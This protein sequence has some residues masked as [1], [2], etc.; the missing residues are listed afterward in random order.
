MR[1]I[2]TR[3]EAGSN[4][5]Q[6]H[7]T[8]ASSLWEQLFTPQSGFGQSKIEGSSPLQATSS[9]QIGPEPLKDELNEQT[10]KKLLNKREKHVHYFLK[11]T[12]RVAG[13]HLCCVVSLWE[14]KPVGTVQAVLAVQIPHPKGDELPPLRRCS[15]F[16]CCLWGGPCCGAFSGCVMSHGR[17]G[18][19]EGSCGLT[20]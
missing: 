14:I 13:V 19:V 18:Q 8:P 1:K 6:A 5:H 20:C 16:S 10:N 9:S 11:R 12:L 17:H 3:A 7:S 2:P 4:S 15:L